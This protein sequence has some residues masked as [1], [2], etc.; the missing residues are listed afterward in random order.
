MWI[1]EWF[2]THDCNPEVRLDWFK[3]HWGF[4]RWVEANTTLGTQ[5]WWE[6]VW[7]RFV[8]SMNLTF[9]RTTTE[10]FNLFLVKPCLEKLHSSSRRRE[11]FVYFQTGLIERAIFAIFYSPPLPNPLALQEPPPVDDGSKH[12]TPRK[13]AVW[14]IG[15]SSHGG[16]GPVSVEKRKQWAC[17]LHLTLSPPPTS[18]HPPTPSEESNPVTLIFGAN[19]QSNLLKVSRICDKSVVLLSIHHGLIRILSK[20]VVT[21]IHNRFRVMGLGRDIG[22]GNTVN[23]PSDLGAL[24]GRY[25][26]H[27]RLSYSPMR[28]CI[29]ANSI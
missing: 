5:D 19:L 8:I 13:T 26:K 9:P 23:R 12:L 14:Q 3:H 22:L 11:T 2:N 4:C 24:L 27:H 1:A 18:L 10:V 20:D 25:E 21:K 29:R 28:E 7:W 17:Q 15:T 16:E 6:I